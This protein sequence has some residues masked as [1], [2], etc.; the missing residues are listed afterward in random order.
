MVYIKMENCYSLLLPMNPKTLRNKV[1]VCHRAGF[2]L[3][4]ILVVIGILAI[5]LVITLIAVNPQRQ[6]IAAADTRRK[7]DIAEIHKSLMEYFVEHHT[8]PTDSQWAAL[9]CGTTVVPTPFNVYMSQLPCDPDPA[10][11]KYF[12]HPLDANCQPCVSGNCMGFRILGKLK[13]TEDKAIESKGCD[14]PNAC[15]VIEPDGEVPN[16]GLSSGECSVYATP[17]PNPPTF[18]PTPTITPGGPTL[19]PT[20]TPTPTAVPTN[21]STPTPSFTPTPTLNPL[22]PTLTPSPSPTFIITPIP[23]TTPNPTF[24]VT[25]QVHLQY[26]ALALE[27]YKFL[28]GQ[29]PVCGGNWM[30]VSCLN[31]SLGSLIINGTTPTDPQLID[32][33]IYIAYSSQQNGTYDGYCLSANFGDPAAN[34]SISNCSIPAPLPIYSVRI[35]ERG[36]II[37]R[38][39]TSGLTEAQK[40]SRDAQRKADIASFIDAMQAYKLANGHYPNCWS[41]PNTW[42]ATGSGAFFCGGQLVGYGSTFNFDPGGNYSYAIVQWN[43]DGNGY[44]QNF[45]Y[46]AYMDKG[47]NTNCSLS[48]PVNDYN[49]NYCYFVPNP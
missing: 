17:N 20:L 40:D 26:I 41:S 7:S 5:L 21:T 22:T 23:N 9:T 3:I 45:C 48:C 31:P 13:N 38:Q 47:S 42:A 37:W 16:Y 32:P 39:V 28:H 49:A 46:G 4:E 18:T 25:R 10:T 30:D 11:Q 8:F 44:Y 1:R 2:T 12:Y 33:Y 29:Y 14:S 43:P 24:D 27:K 15:G 19:T 34:S 6:F 36:E 35:K